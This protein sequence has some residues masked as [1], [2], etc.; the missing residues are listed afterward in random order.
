MTRLRSSRT[1]RPGSWVVALTLTL[2]GAAS[3]LAAHETRPGLLEITETGPETYSLLWKRPSGGEVEIRIAPVVPEECRF[4]APDQQQLTPGAEIV[5][6]TLQCPGGL[7]G[8]TLRIGGLETTIT[9]VLVRLHHAD[10]RLES[11]VLRPVAPA[12]VL[13]GATTRR[14]AGDGLPAPGRRAHP[15]RRGPSVVRARP[16][17]HRHR[18][19]DAPEDGERLHPGA[20]DHPR[21]RDPGLRLGAG[22]AAQRGDRALDPLS[23]SR[24][25]AALARRVEL[26]HSPSLG[27]GLRL[28]FAARLRLRERPHLHGAAAGGDPGC[29]AAVQRR[30]R[31]RAS[32]SSSP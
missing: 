11:H 24:N 15:A 26:H 18:P 5:R 29:A 31:G 6:G 17:A 4:A 28:R 12:V 30:R 16:A 25:R 14:A 3:P 1:R 7:A 22:A 32:S 13:G 27:G 19:L 23:R 10:G 21:H 20:L 2:A 8:K 9:D